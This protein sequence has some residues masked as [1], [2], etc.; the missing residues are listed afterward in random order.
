M[1]VEIR[2]PIMIIAIMIVSRIRAQILSRI[3]AQILSR[4]H[5]QILSRIH[6]QILSRIH[7]QILILNPNGLNRTLSALEETSARMDVS[8]IELISDC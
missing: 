7:A 1:I 5:A 8:T 6:A 4:I 3:H 2:L